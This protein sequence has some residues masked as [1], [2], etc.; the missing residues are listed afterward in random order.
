MFD[1]TPPFD[2]QALELVSHRRHARIALLSIILPSA[3]MLVLF[4]ATQA[5]FLLFPLPLIIGVSALNFYILD[6]RPVPRRLQMSPEGI[7]EETPEGQLRE[8]AWG[9]VHSVREH[10]QTLKGR[11]RTEVYFHDG[12]APVYLYPFAMKILSTNGE[13]DSGRF[14]DNLVVSGV[15]WDRP[16]TYARHIIAQHVPTF[17]P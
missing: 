17:V 16:V 1:R 3:L 2:L 4:F 7:K 12:R 10:L 14:S 5:T 13:P 15:R 6:S 8:H 11:H 9:E